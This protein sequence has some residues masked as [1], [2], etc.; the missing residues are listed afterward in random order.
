MGMHVN[1]PEM[2]YAWYST[3][4]RG[5]HFRPFFH[6][7][8]Q[9]PFYPKEA[10][11]LSQDKK[12]VPDQVGQ[13]EH[14]KFPVPL[15]SYPMMIYPY[16]L[17]GNRPYMMGQP[18]FNPHQHFY[19]SYPYAVHKSFDSEE[20]QSGVD[21]KSSVKEEL[22]SPN[23]SSSS[24]HLN[25]QPSAP[26]AGSNN[27]SV[28]KF[29]DKTNTGVSNDPLS[30]ISKDSNLPCGYGIPNQDYGN[31]YY[32]YPAVYGQ[33]PRDSSDGKRPNYGPAP[34]NYPQFHP[35]VPGIQ[36]YVMNQIPPGYY[37][38][39]FNQ[40]PPFYGSYPPVNTHI[41]VPFSGNMPP[42]NPSNI[43]VSPVRVFLE[44]NYYSQGGMHVP[45]SQP[46]NYNPANLPVHLDN[47]SQLE[48]NHQDPSQ[49]PLVNFPITAVPEAV[50]NTQ[51]PE[52]IVSPV[53]IL[54]QSSHQFLNTNPGSVN[55]T[56]LTINRHIIQGN[57]SESPLNSA[58][59]SVRRSDSS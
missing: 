8:F 26:E 55:L 59:S 28:S 42:Q 53:N 32:Y 34:Q 18:H 38:H 43:G 20:S 40:Y 35:H 51:N 49:N 19:G 23:L 24:S 33:H 27:S 54:A 2:N 41:G 13:A 5:H 4:S 57:Y 48:Q 50:S 58:H 9:R 46:K 12:D 36:P 21:L 17:Y 15:N 45:V 52:N 6:Q 37:G 1:H 22:I 44:R 56:P 10:R 7:G 25:L 47:I 16:D 11:D 3:D 29:L 30:K 14:Q 31:Y 39:M